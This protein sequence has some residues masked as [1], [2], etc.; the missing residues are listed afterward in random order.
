MLGGTSQSDRGMLNCE[1]QPLNGYCDGSMSCPGRGAGGGGGLFTYGTSRGC[2]FGLR[3]IR[4]R[5][6]FVFLRN[7]QM[8]ETKF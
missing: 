4:T 3:H 7:S 6:L 1:Q 8:C 5:V 2:L